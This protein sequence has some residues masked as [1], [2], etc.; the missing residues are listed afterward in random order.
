[1]SYWCQKYFEHEQKCDL[2]SC[3]QKSGGEIAEAVFER[4]MPSNLKYPETVA[5]VDYLKEI[6]AKCKGQR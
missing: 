1:M 3:L 2:R 4:R 5:A 6:C